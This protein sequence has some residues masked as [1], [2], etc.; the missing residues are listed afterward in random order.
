MLYIVATPI[1]N[2]S[3][4]TLRALETLKSVDI[5]TCEDTRVS[6][7]LL[8]HFGIK[9]PLMSLHQHSGEEVIRKLVDLLIGG[10][11]I[12]YITDGGTP[13]I[14]DPGQKLVDSI[15]LIANNSG[16][17]ITILPIPGPSAVVTAISVSGMVEKEF[18]FAGFLPKKKGRQTKMIQL[19]KINTP[20]VIYE[21][22]LRLERTLTDVEQYFGKDCEIF[23]AREMTKM[24]EEYWSGEVIN[25]I[26]DLKNH[27]LKGEFVL[28]VKRENF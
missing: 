26:T 21:S 24:F 8:D 2:L 23:I 15:K 18:Y 7:K 25:I 5:I 11:N 6:R 9:K 28:V 17:Q 3:D 20:I 12:A 14:S 10:K 27:K 1:G 22:A 13:G 4:I 19:S 16:K